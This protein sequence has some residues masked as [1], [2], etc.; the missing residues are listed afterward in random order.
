MNY[1][2]ENGEHLF[3]VGRLSRK[4]GTVFALIGVPVPEFM[5]QAGL[6][7]RLCK[8]IQATAVKVIGQV[9]DDEIEMPQVTYED[10]DV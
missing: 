3:I 2:I 8:P 5:V 4:N 9:P 1:L 6:D 10:I 7:G